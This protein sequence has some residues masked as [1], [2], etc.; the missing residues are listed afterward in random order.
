MNR[1]TPDAHGAHDHEQRDVN[2]KPVVISTIGLLVVLAVAFALMVGLFDLF[3]F[4]EARLS[5][6]ANPLAAA[7][8]RRLPPEPRLQSHPLRDLQ[9]LRRA[10]REIL[11]SYAWVDKNAGVVR[12]PVARAMELLATRAEPG[13]AAAR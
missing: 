5:P 7:E 10:E 11:D 8:G 4:Q 12:I 1:V 2:L 9:D 6:P 13:E 3:A